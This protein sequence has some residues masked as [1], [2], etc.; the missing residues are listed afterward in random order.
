MTFELS[1]ASCMA[2]VLWST[3]EALTVTGVLLLI[4]V[5][6]LLFRKSGLMLAEG[7]GFSGGS[8]ATSSKGSRSAAKYVK[9][10]DIAW[11]PKGAS[12]LKH[13]FPLFFSSSSDPT[14][15][16]SLYGLSTTGS[17]AAVGS[18][19]VAEPPISSSWAMIP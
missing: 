5:A 11:K 18:G 17:A 6:A 3:V 16:S 7:V 12:S 1:A 10:N 4:S 9:R 2:C 15:S 19:H 13:F 8:L 14:P